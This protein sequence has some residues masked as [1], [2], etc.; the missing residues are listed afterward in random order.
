MHSLLI[1][2]S[3]FVQNSFIIHLKPTQKQS[4][5]MR[6]SIMRMCSSFRSTEMWLGVRSQ[7]FQS[8]QRAHAELIQNSFRSHIEL[9]QNLFTIRSEFIQSPLRI[10]TEFIENSFKI[11][12]EL[13]Q[14]SVWT[15]PAGDH[16][17]SITYNINPSMQSIVDSTPSTARRGAE[18]RRLRLI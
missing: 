12:S 14:N 4:E 17:R 10:H 16:S 18:T 2:H 3:Q 9:T 13:V 1:H 15:H 5:R 6:N 8:S 11:H 7:N